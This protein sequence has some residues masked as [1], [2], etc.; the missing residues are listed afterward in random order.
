MNLVRKIVS[1]VANES[2]IV[3][4]ALSALVT[5]WV[6]FGFRA[7]P[8]Q[9]AAVATIG[10]AVVAIVTAFATRP[11]SVPVITGAVATIATASAAFG[12]H[13][14][15]AQIG[16][17]VPVLSLVLSLVLRQAVTP[18]VTLKRQQAHQPEH[19][20]GVVQHVEHTG[21]FLSD[22][23]LE[24]LAGRLARAARRRPSAPRTM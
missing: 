1:L 23:D 11:V 22:G 21:R 7:S 9:T 3:L 12:L 2:A 19:A 16:A 5:A 6:A 8:A 13:L 24:A 18:L 10:T 4:Y 20:L 14:T 15:S 17:A